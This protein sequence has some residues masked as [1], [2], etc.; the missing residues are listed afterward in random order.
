[1]WLSLLGVGHKACF[2]LTLLRFRRRMG[3]PPFWGSACGLSVVGISQAWSVEAWYS[4][5]LDIEEVLAQIGRDQLHVMVAGFVLGFSWPLDW[6]SHGVEMAASRRDVLLVWF[7]L[8][9]CM[10]PGEG[11][12]PSVTP[13]LH[14]DNL[15]GRRVFGA[16]NL[17]IFKGSLQV[18]NSTHLMEREKCS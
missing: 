16:R 2:A 3:T 4:A 5:A 9:P 10:Y 18:L 11:A 7:S 6:V 13:Q 15:K 12:M 1:M 14:A 17:L 8:L